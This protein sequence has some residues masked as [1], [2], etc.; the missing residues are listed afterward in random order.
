MKPTTLLQVFVLCIAP[1][2]TSAGPP[3]PSKACR[4]LPEKITATVNVYP[5]A[6]V[7]SIPHEFLGTNL[8]QY[9]TDK[10]QIKNPETLARV[11]ALGVKTVRFPNGCFADLYN[12]Q[13][14]APNEVTVDEL[15]DFCDAIKAEP[16]Y[17]FNMQGGTEGREGKPPEKAP[18]EEVIKYRHVAPNP[19][20]HTKYH[21]G[22]LPEALTLLQKYTIDRA[23]AGN[24][25]ILA[26]ELGNENWGQSKTD[27]TPAVYG[28]TC[29]IWC[30]ELRKALAEA[31]AQHPTLAGLQ[32]HITAVG[33]PTMGNN[34]D[35]LKATDRQINIEWTAEI[36]RL[37]GAKLID[38]V[39]EHFYPYPGNNGDAVIWTLHNLHNILALRSGKPS[40]RLGGYRDPAL[41]FLCPLEVTEWNIKCWGRNRPRTDLPLKN[42][43]FENGLQDWTAEA[44]PAAGGKARSTNGAA[45][46]GKSGVRLATTPKGERVEIRQTFSVADRPNAAALG[47]YVWVKSK[48]PLQLHVVLRQANEGPSQGKV[49]DERIATQTSTWER[50]CV[51]QPPFEDTRAVELIIR[52]EGPNAVADIDEVVP[53]HWT[54][55]SD[56][57]P[58]AAERFE[59]Q[60]FAVDALR[61]MLSFGIVRTH[62]HHLFGNYPCPQLKADG[63]ARDNAAAFELLN[64]RIGDRLIRSECKAPTFDYNTYADKYATDFNAVTPDVTNVPSI[65]AIATRE[66]SN[67]YILLVNRTTDRPVS[68]AVNLHDA[69]PAGVGDCRTLLGELDVQGA[70]LKNAPLRPESLAQHVIPPF[71]A[72]ALRIPLAGSPGGE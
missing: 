50:L 34:Q 71:S 36:N 66:G 46:R 53:I 70:K 21:F 60:L 30:R 16:Y 10:R 51:G 35:P 44:T 68:L 64:D 32:L 55:F 48:T 57:I 31:Q 49:L 45:R 42:G 18:L 40:V 9:E 72:Q 24:A 27:W 13:K 56:S 37:A 58:P 47:A 62:W 22:T 29:E 15:L 4:A 41:A 61:E 52:L 63:T 43:G 8:T 3:L 7:R 23:L 69:K 19:C 11:K 12:W 5:Q 39:Q 28:K 25:P 17:T 67:L 1:T 38:A 2:V 6:A 14:P 59:Q 33:F 26:Y 54:A 20:G 65:S